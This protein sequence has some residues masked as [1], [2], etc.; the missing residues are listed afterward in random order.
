[1]SN[2][3]IWTLGAS[4]QPFEKWAAL[5]DFAAGTKH[6]FYWKDRAD[7]LISDPESSGTNSYLGEEWDFYL[8]WK[9]TESLRWI[10]RYGIFLPDD[11]YP[12]GARD[13]TEYFF[14]STSYSF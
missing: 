14:L 5:K 9:A 8:H 2:I 6:Y 13:N 7:G 4:F 11:G 3:R 1:M 12:D 10:M